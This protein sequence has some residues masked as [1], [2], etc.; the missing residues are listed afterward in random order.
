MLKAAA[1]NLPGRSEPAQDRSAVVVNHCLP[2]LRLPQYQGREWI[3]ANLPSGCESWPVETGRTHAGRANKPETSSPWHWPSEPVFFFGDPHADAEA[4]MASLVAS[5]GIEKTGHE[6]HAFRLTTAGRNALFILAG[7][8][9]DKGPGNLRLIRTLR[10]LLKRGARM[11]ILAGNHD[12]RVLLGMRS[13]NSF[14]LTRNEHFFIRMG[15]KAVPLL[16]EIHRQYL[17]GRNA[18]RNVPGTDECRRRLYP[19]D[20]WYEIFPELARKTMPAQTVD[21]ELVRLHRKLDSFE[22]VCNAAGLTLRDVY[23]ATLKWQSLFLRP[24]GEF[25]WFFRTI[26][27]ASQNGSF[28]F[29]H[30][31]LDDRIAEVVD[32][33]GIR[34]LNR[35]FRKQLEGDAFGLY[36][37][38]IGNCFRTKYREVDMPFTGKGAESAR[39]AGIHAVVHGHRNVLHGQRIVRRHD[40]INFECDTTMD[41]NSRKKEGLEG[42][43][44]GVTIIKPE[45]VVM[46]ISSDY[47]RIKLYS[48]DGNMPAFRHSTAGR[49]G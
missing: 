10:L 30:A 6:D 43:G 14:R 5:G 28:L 41:C 44:A 7:D 15:A 45:G 1:H 20:T 16:V 4:L 12:V 35:Q 13:V 8:C 31:G 38:P 3:R 46:G 29:I 17:A 9:F 34:Y 49:Q 2:V 32:R 18:L 22:D 23:A 47:P 37:G 11:H 25:Y 39:H 48:Q 27:L 36:Y 26:Q 33:Y 42:P 19:S 24:E 40:M 21:R